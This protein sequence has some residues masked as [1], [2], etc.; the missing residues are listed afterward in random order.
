VRGSGGS[1]RIAPLPTICL[2]GALVA[3]TVMV[4]G[5]P[6]AAARGRSA[7]GHSHRSRAP[8]FDSPT[9]VAVVGA[10]LFVANG[11]GNT[12]TEVSAS[13]GSYV[14]QMRARRYRFDD[15]SAIASIGSELF[16]ANAVGNSVTDFMASGRKRVRVIR[17]GFEDPIALAP[18][19]QDL[20]ALNGTGSITELSSVTGRLIGTISGPAFG[21]DEP[22]G[23]AVA[24]GRIF[25]AN[26]AAD[27]VTVINAATRAFVATLSG[28][29]FEFSTPIGVAFDGTNMWVTNQDGESVTEFSPT[30]LQALNVLVSSNLPWVGPVI[31]G[32]GYVFA[33]SPPGSSPMV[34]QIT[35]SPAAVNWMMC[36]TNGPYAFN[37][38]QSAVVVG[39]VLWVINQGGNSLTEMDASSGNLIETVS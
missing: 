5:G 23:L 16:V 28:S 31:Y 21:F 12:V 25:V 29:Q 14:A 32:D 8:E 37:D 11:G 24:D 18:S 1:V 35:P 3:G 2:V 30:S 6:A 26:S 20:F 15:P 27:T 33:I 34:S 22:T 36:N 4:V 38:P 7:H 10:D 9:S 19:G 17:G 39:P 13:D